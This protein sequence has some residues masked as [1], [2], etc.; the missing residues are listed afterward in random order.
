MFQHNLFVMGGTLQLVEVLWYTG[1]LCIPQHV[2][3]LLKYSLT[4]VL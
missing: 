3:L 2:F 1:V 4:T